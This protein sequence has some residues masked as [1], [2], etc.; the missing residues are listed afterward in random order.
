MVTRA[1][2]R[3]DSLQCIDVLLASSDFHA[4]VELMLDYKFA[5][6]E[7]ADEEEDEGAGTPSAGRAYGA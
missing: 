3:G 5:L 1:R 4:F 2:E 7:E 6:A